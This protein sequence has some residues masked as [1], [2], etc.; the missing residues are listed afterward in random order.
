MVKVEIG[1]DPSKWARGGKK[2]DRDTNKERERERNT[3]RDTE[4]E[5]EER[6]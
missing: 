3:E 2:T 6:Y 1:G 5:E 4:R